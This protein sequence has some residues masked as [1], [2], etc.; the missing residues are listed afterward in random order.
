MSSEPAPDTAELTTMAEEGAPPSLKTVSV[1]SVSGL[2]TYVKDES[3]AVA[4]GKAFF[5]DQATGSDGLACASCHFHAGADS[6]VKNQLN[7]GTPGGDTRFGRTQKGQGGPNYTL[8]EKDFPF[9]R[10]KEPDDRASGL[11]FD[12]DDVAS[13]QGVYNGDFRNVTD[14]ATD[15]CERWPD[16]IF[17]VGGVGTRRVEP[18]NSPSTINA[19]FNFRNFWD[20]R[21]N[22]VFNGVDPF[23]LRNAQARVLVSSGS[24]VSEQRVDLRNSSLASQGVGPAVSNVEMIC[25]GR[26]FANF[27][28]KLVPRYALSLQNVAPNDSVLGSLRRGS[29][30]G[31]STTY[32]ELIQDAFRDEYWNADGDFGG[33]TQMESNFS[34]FWGLALQV[35]QA[36]LVSDEA[37]YDNWAE[38]NSKAL[39]KNQQAGLDIFMGDGKCINCHKGP[40]F[41]GAASVL[42]KENQEGG[43]VERMIMNDGGVALYDDGFYNIGVTRTAADLGVGEKDPFGNPL[44]FTRQYA[45]G[46][47][48]D[49]FKVNPCTFE[50]KF[51]FSNCSAEPANLSSERTAVDG[52]FKVPILRN[53]ELT[54]PFFHDGSSATLEQVVEHYNRG[55]NFQN[56]ELDADIEPL[57]LSKE[58]K[59]NLVA[60]L[61]S[62]TDDRVRFEKAPF[63]HPQLYIPNGH[64]GDE[65]RA[66][67]GEFAQADMAVTE[68]L[69]V[70]A[71]GQNGRKDALKTFE[72]TLKKGGPDLPKAKPFNPNNRPPVL[73]LE[74]DRVNAVG[75]KIKEELSATD[76]NGDKITFSASGLPEGLKL[77]KGGKLEGKL[78]EAGEY[79]VTVIAYD[80]QLGTTTETFTWTVQ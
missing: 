29:Q 50:V 39:D 53:V 10:F 62:L 2:S 58:D 69:E 47:F 60:F 1:P 17:H 24:G 32:E 57:G 43:L 15:E 68:W 52:A 51:D 46:N 56:P 38:G 7:P 8:E 66:Q 5:W 70:R 54:G 40:E 37:P 14:T 61:E 27:G 44:S 64:P 36:T 55:G 26:A 78:K 6:R 18:R 12:T 59:K 33:F 80:E 3:A 16:D 75:D 35:Y 41:S 65:K 31:L 45:S 71:V 19:T 67:G 30:K 28:R 9:H 79:T 74:G 76:P 72:D 49:P 77:D 20:G 34:L 73:A 21:A 42:Q 4:L 63:D 13:S 22:N 23:G 48:V 11:E 25:S